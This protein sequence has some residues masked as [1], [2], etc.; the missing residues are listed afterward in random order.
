MSIK[1]TPGPWTTNPV[2]GETWV[3]DTIGDALIARVVVD[4]KSGQ[5][6]AKLIAATPD[7]AEALRTL[8]VALPEKLA[9]F[10]ALHQGV[11]AAR[12]ALAKAGL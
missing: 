10:G 6:N 3:Y 5:L 9:P 7:L 2:D 1:H 11:E 4:N 8:L 12:A